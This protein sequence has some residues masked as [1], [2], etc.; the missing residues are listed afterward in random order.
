MAG[1]VIFTAIPKR[2][3]YLAGVAG[4]G[5]RIGRQRVPVHGGLFVGTAPIDPIQ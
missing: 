4:S 2:D 1:T 5:L 3:S